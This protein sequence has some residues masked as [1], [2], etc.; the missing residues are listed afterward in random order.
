MSSSSHAMP[1]PWW[2]EGVIY[3][4]YPLT[5]ADGNGDGTGDLRGI[6]ARLDYLNDGDPDSETCLGID[7]I[8]LSPINQS[9]MIDNGYDVVDYTDICPIFGTL[10]DFD[11]LLDQA[12]QRG[13]KIVMDLVVNHTS[14]QHSWFL[15]SAS[16]R[17]HPKADWYLWQDAWEGRDLPNNWQS[18]FG[19][20]GWTYAEE[21]GQF[22]F[23]TFNEN[24]PDLNWQNPEVRAAIYD[25]IRFWLDRGVDG[26]RLDASSAYSQDPYFRDNP[27]KYGASD[28]NAYNNYHHLYD[29]NLPENHQIIKEIRA[30]LEEYGDRLLIGETFID[31]RLYDSIV[32]YGVNNDELHFP[33]TFEFP[34]SPWYP[35]YLQRQIEKTEK[36]TP[37]GAWPT[38]FLDNHDI[39]RHLSRWIECSLCVDSVAIAKAAATLLLTVRGTP[40]LYYGQEL[41]M[42]DNT[43]IPANKLQ[44]RA[45]VKSGTGETPPP[46]DGARTPM[47]WDDF[48]QAG[49]S[50]GRD[51]DP[52]LP[53]HTNYHQ[54]NVQAALQDPD[55]I[56]TFYRQLI[57]VR[58]R[59]GALRRGQWRPL[60]HYPHE[61]LA[62]VRETEAET[63]LVLINF[64]YEKPLEL[65]VLVNR[66]AWTVLLSTTYKTG[67]LIDLPDTLQPFEVSIVQKLA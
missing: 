40:I 64:S 17:D 30:I 14:N 47:Q 9:P 22:Y 37:V 35:G 49:F 29:R 43:E 20:T 8:W 39:P 65:D 44:D 61:H 23:H 52:W 36:V 41:G 6:I 51:V 4:I 3:Q 13:I 32:F 18:Y 63:V 48:P 56:L 28:K 50:F 1:Q 67:K 2:E 53:V 10:A 54:L 46:R 66:E 42:V 16:S 19:G 34:F 55:S 27:L 11:E 5:F 60:I 26:F 38:Y 21:R 45:V 25:I 12:H 59:S 33:L 62:Y 24:Q 31:N 58:R 7:A 15:E 57:Q